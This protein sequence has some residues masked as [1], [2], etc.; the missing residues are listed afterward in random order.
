MS[1]SCVAPSQDDE[2]LILYTK[3]EGSVDM[4]KLEEEPTGLLHSA[5][6][7]RQLILDHPDLPLLVFAGDDCNTGDYSYMTCSY[8][9]AD[10]GEFLDC[11]QAIN[12]ERCYT[13]RDEFEED[14]TDCLSKGFDG[15]ANEFDKLIE[16]QL[17]Y[18]ERFW[19]P[20]IILFVNN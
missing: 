19:K 20:C 5:T 16:D 17:W 12:E 15:S 1:K 18:Y 6:K 10:V 9:S 3:Q 4:R 14:L 8:V 2:M 13:D 7:L 11:N